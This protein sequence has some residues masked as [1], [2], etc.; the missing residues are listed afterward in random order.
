MLITGSRVVERGVFLSVVFV[1]ENVVVG[2][3]KQ[4]GYCQKVAFA[5]LSCVLPVVMLVFVVAVQGYGMERAGRFAVRSVG[6][7]FP[8]CKAYGACG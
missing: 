1:F 6:F 2:F 5:K 8:D 7:V 4:K 3:L